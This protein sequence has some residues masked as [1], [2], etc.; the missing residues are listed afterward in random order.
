MAAVFETGSASGHEAE[1]RC[2]RNSRLAPR[3]LGTTPH[4][5][6]K[7]RL[8][9]RIR[10]CACRGRHRRS[11]W[12]R[13]L[14]GHRG[15][16]GRRWRGWWQARIRRSVGWGRRFRC[17]S[18]E[19]ACILAVPVSRVAL[20]ATPGLCALRCPAGR[21]F[22]SPLQGRQE[23]LDHGVVLLLADVA[24]GSCLTEPEE[25]GVDEVAAAVARRWQH[26]AAWVAVHPGQAGRRPGTQGAHPAV[27]PHD[28]TTLSTC[29]HV[30][31][32]LVVVGNVAHRRLAAA[33]HLS[34]PAQKGEGSCTTHCTPFEFHSPELTTPLRC[35]R[36]T[37]G[38]PFPRWVGT[39]VGAFDRGS[40]AARCPG[41]CY[42]AARGRFTERA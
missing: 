24:I 15:W 21:S 11:A 29:N 26:R 12:R 33:P 13:R 4:E 35:Q 36:C 10:H 40:A 23:S 38:A 7:T 34:E 22:V 28:R 3:P 32:W 42:P 5:V 17:R 39:F 9:A 16:W 20:R 31:S 25:E 6:Q 2:A 27:G 1:S 18:R 37:R 14:D 19:P 41:F 30:Q 8:P